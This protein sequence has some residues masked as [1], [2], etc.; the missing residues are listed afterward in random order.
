MQQ[1]KN[2]RGSWPGSGHPNRSNIRSAARTAVVLALGSAG[3]LACGSDEEQPAPSDVREI[4]L[5]PAL[6]T[7]VFVKNLQVNMPEDGTIELDYDAKV[8]IEGKGERDVLVFTIVEPL[9]MGG[10]QTILTVE[11]SSGAERYFHLESE[12]DAVVVGDELGG[13]FVFHN[14]DDSY[15]VVTAEFDQ[16]AS[17]DQYEHAEDGYAAWQLI[18]QYN[19]FT[20]ASAFNL[21]MAYAAAQMPTFEAR[22]MQECDLPLCIG[23]LGG[24]AASSPPVCQTFQAFC[25]CVACAAAGAGESCSLCQAP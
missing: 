6:G 18:Q 1:T 4:V 17:E 2:S 16:P 9:A 14:P 10:R 8:S 7:K 23:G 25:D 22:Q 15:D 21:I 19:Q 13:V 24:Q 11:T 12:L 20:D 3:L 5:D